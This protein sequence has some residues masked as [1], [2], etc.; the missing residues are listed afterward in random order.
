MIETILEEIYKGKY[1]I[2]SDDKPKNAFPASLPYEDGK[3]LYETV[4]AT[5]S[6]RTLEIGMA[7][8]ASTLFIL[9]ALQVNGGGRH[10]AIDPYQQ[11]W[12][13]GIGLKNIARAG[14]GEAVRLIE[15]PSHIALPHLLESKERFD[16]IFID[17]NHRFEYTLVDFFYADKL[18]PVGGSIMLHDV[19]LP[20]IK[21]VLSYICRNQ[22][23]AYKVEPA[24]HGAT[25]RGLSFWR[26]YYR[27]LRS[28]PFD[29][30]PAWYFALYPLNRYCVL[31]KTNEVDLE[32][33]DADWN[34]YRPF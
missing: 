29:I 10:V 18:I 9:Q 3:A 19:W 25:R 20:S 17:G 6:A 31:K 21:K 11:T 27:C 28:A 8:G 33:L 24:F 26:A 5:K 13:E 34:Y 12:W 16:F 1:V 14:H 4:V 23:D 15:A 7:Y 22:R 30:L 32:T 2:G